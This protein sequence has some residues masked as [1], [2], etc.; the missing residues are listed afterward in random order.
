MEKKRVRKSGFYF[1]GNKKP[2]K[3]FDQENGRIGALS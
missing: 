1:A 2:L 3:G